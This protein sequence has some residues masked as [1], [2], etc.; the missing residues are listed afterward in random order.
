MPALM[1]EPALD[2]TRFT[3]RESPAAQPD[4]ETDV[5]RGLTA[6]QKAIPPLYF[7]DAL[8]SALFEAI[9]ELP[10]YYIRRSEQEVFEKLGDA[11]VSSIGSPRRLIELGSGSARKTRQLLDRLGDRDMQYIPIDVDG[12]TLTTTARDL[13]A[14][15][16]RLRI[17][18]VRGDFRNAADSVRELAATPE[19]TVILFLGS[20][21]GNLDHPDA[22]RLLHSLRGLLHAG[23][24]FLLGVDLRKS[25]DILEPAYDDPLGVTAAFNLNLLRRINRELGGHFDVRMFGHR[26]FYDVPNGRI[27][28]H[29]V[30]L[31]DQSV[32][33]DGLGIDV[34]F[35]EAETIHTEDSYKYDDRSLEMLAR[36]S[37]F[38][39]ERRWADSKG[40]FGDV[41][42]RV[43]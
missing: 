8:G 11:I 43:T 6:P 38:A 36:E 3:L 42:M 33:I 25:K 21:I 15:Y 13:L 5:G 18:A 27:E 12:T 24:S 39:I 37:G 1:P 16:P 20:S 31:R 34:P 10:E 26:A 29:L 30:S 14:A 41:L 19:P 7:Y 23:D 32:R 9:C 35:A 40:W 17:D 22:V 28:M 2:P 4:F